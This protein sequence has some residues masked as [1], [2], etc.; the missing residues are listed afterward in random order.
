MRQQA[1]LNEDSKMKAV[2]KIDW[3]KS[4]LYRLMHQEQ[5]RDDVKRLET[6]PDDKPEMMQE[7][8]IIIVLERI[9]RIRA[10]TLSNEDKRAFTCMIPFSITN[11][12]GAIEFELRKILTEKYC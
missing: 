11:S 4:E 6:E 10:N 5:L 12:E 2:I 9:K 7:G 8:E 1:G 3:Q